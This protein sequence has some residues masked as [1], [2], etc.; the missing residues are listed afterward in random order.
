MP[1]K[2]LGDVVTAKEWEELKKNLP[3]VSLHCCSYDFEEAVDKGI[4]CF[5]KEVQTRRE[6]LKNIEQERV[7]FVRLTEG[8]RFELKKEE[9]NALR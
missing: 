8:I 3:K 1:V 2:T 4:E 9:E 5:T 6:R 7:R